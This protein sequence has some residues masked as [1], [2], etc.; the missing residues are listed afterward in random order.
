MNV[1]RAALPQSILRL[2]MC[3]RPADR[4]EL[5]DRQIMSPSTG[6]LR[7]VPCTP[8]QILGKVFD[9]HANRARPEVLVMAL[10]SKDGAAVQSPTATLR[11]TEG[12]SNPSSR[13][14]TMPVV[15]CEC[16]VGIEASV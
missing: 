12:P 15:V 16:K 3:M 11:E 10:S 9:A 14:H 1:N 2:G 4:Y 6:R 8:A 5:T 13:R 7:Y